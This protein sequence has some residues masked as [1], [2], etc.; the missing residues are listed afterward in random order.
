MARA[1][2]LSRQLSSYY[3]VALQDLAMQSLRRYP[4]GVDGIAAK[5][6]K[7]C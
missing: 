1:C 6:I 5:G 7:T 2:K 4:T 3:A